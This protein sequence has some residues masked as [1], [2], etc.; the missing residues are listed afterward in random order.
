[1]YSSGKTLSTNRMVIESHRPVADSLALYRIDPIP[2]QGI[3]IKRI[4]H[5]AWENSREILS[6]S[7]LHGFGA[8]FATDTFW[9]VKLFW[10]LCLILS[11]GYFAYVGYNTVKLYQS[12]P[13]VTQISK[14]SETILDFPGNQSFFF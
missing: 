12:Y 13:K 8:I 3:Q 4:F 10:I 9:I 14:A 11:W 7:T 6:R 2:V 1:M 5:S